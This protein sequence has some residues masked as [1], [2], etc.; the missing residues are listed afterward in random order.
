M[1]LFDKLFSHFL[2]CFV[3]IKI[4]TTSVLH[5]SE[6]PMNV[7]HCVEPGCYSRAINYNA[8]SKQMSALAELSIECRQSISVSHSS[9]R[10]QKSN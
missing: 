9:L 5:D 2:W 8:S 4:G 3:G 6:S 1:T 7:G 10:V